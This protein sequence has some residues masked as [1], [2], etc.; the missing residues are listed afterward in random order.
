MVLFPPTQTSQNVPQQVFQVVGRAVDVV[1][2]VFLGEITAQPAEKLIASLS[3]VPK[4]I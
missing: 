3:N 2:D 1:V 4:D